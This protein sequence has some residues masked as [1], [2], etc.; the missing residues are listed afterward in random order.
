LQ[1]Y[2]NTAVSNDN[3]RLKQRYA[4]VLH[5]GYCSSPSR[6]IVG[7]GPFM[8]NHNFFINGDKLYMK[9]VVLVEIYNFVVNFFPLEMT[10]RLK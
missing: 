3:R 10:F 5:R 1:S 4:T 7:G 6:C 8:K 9:N 2:T